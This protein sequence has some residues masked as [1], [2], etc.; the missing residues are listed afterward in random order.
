MSRGHNVGIIADSTTGAQR[1]ES[2]LAQLAPALSLGVRRI[3]M[4]RHIGIS[5]V[6]AA[7]AVTQ[8]VAEHDAD[9]IHGHGAKGGAYAR[10]TRGHAIRV[11]TP[12]GGSLHYRPTS[13][14][15]LIYLNLERLL[16]ARSDLFL[17]ESAYAHRVF[18]KQVGILAAA[19][20]VVH[21]GLTDAEFAPIEPDVDATDLIFVGELR[22]LKGVDVLIEALALLANAGEAVSAT[23]VGDGPDARTFRKLATSRGLDDQIHFAGPLPARAAFARGQV[24]VVPSRAE[25]LPYIVLE[26]AA[27]GRPIIATAVGGIPEIFGPEADKLV[28]PA[29]A[30][31]L[32]H[33]IH[34]AVNDLQMANS[35]ARRL[36]TH[37]RAGFSV[38]T[39]AEQILDAYG[40]ALNFKNRSFLRAH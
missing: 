33:A 1:A 26:A 6:A 10:L 17:F 7:R 20:R 19:A 14:L 22:I 13:P 29:N 37:V 24:V 23:I 21:N 11:Y 28:E 16:M 4:S 8:A 32:A 40:E 38:D 25:S 12:H 9:V 30:Q 35:D 5:D 27:V 2:I 18:Q 36:R 31:T 3:R 15:G 34:A 39:M